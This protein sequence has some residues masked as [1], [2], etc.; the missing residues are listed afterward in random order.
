MPRTNATGRTHRYATTNDQLHI[1]AEVPLPAIKAEASGAKT[2]APNLSYLHDIDPVL[3][4]RQVRLAIGVVSHSTLW[5]WVQ[6]GDFPPSIRI[7][8]RRIGWRKSA[9]VKW[10]AE[11]EAEADRR[12]GKAA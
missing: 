3:S 1:Q 9:V 10:L 4:S 11:R 7:G 6:A 12:Y 5:R 8:S 2:K